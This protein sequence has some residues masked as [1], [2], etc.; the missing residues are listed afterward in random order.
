M[1]KISCKSTRAVVEIITNI[2]RKQGLGLCSFIEN[3]FVHYTSRITV[4]T[5]VITFVSKYNSDKGS[6]KF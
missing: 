5:A 4:I 1:R 2:Y 6:R 3:I